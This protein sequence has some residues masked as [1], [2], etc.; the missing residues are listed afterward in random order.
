MRAKVKK[1]NA[2]FSQRSIAPASSEARARG[3]RAGGAKGKNATSPA[4]Q[5]EKSKNNGC[6][7][8]VRL[9]SE[10]LFNEA[11][12]YCRILRDYT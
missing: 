2:T 3:R 6:R 10:R 9:A 4:K 8:Q 7:H 1:Q 11:F 5:G 12:Y